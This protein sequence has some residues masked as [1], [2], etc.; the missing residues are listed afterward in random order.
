[1][2]DLFIENELLI[3]ATPGKV[4]EVLTSPTQ[5][6]KF[7]FGCTVLCDWQ[8]G[9]P[10]TWEGVEDG[11]TYVKGHLLVFENQKQFSYTVFDP[12]AAY[13]DIPENYLTV[14]IWIKQEGNQTL[15]KVSQGDYA[16]VAD[17]QKRYEDTLAGGGWEAVLN[18][19]K[20]LAETT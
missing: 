7:M 17:G 14:N 15:V 12:N 8:I 6:P 4:W 20:G 19:V 13:E 11:I 18:T 10:I 16:Q 9:S 3:G 5:V 1:M 2:K